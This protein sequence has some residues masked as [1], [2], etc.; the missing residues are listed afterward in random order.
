MYWLS[1]P[2][3]WKGGDFLTG[4]RETQRADTQ[5]NLDLEEG[6]DD[7]DNI[8]RL[9]RQQAHPAPSRKPSTVAKIYRMIVNPGKSQDVSEGS[10]YFTQSNLDKA[11]SAIQPMGHSEYVGGFK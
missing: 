7:G 9:P 11:I 4:R 1:R 10:A 3:A 2:H 6:E 8:Q 5:R